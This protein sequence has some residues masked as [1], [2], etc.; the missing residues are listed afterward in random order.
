MINLFCIKMLKKMEDDLKMASQSS[1]RNV[2]EK[3]PG[4]TYR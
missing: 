3:F 2:L 4:S 1:L